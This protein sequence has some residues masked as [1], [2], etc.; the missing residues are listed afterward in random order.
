MIGPISRVRPLQGIGTEAKLEMEKL[1]KQA[2]EQI[3]KIVLESLPDPE[4]EILAL[5]PF[6]NE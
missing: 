1:R 3:Y 4:E 6:T 2:E 5:K